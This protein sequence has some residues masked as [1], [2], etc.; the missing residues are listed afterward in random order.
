MPYLCGVDGLEKTNAQVAAEVRFGV[1]F[2]ERIS[3]L[4]V[5]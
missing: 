4:N 5:N 2:S 3:T 1:L